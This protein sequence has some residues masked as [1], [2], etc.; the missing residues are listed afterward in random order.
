KEKTFHALT[1]KVEIRHL[2]VK[3]HN[4]YGVTDYSKPIFCTFPTSWP[5]LPNV[6]STIHIHSK[7]P[8]KRPESASKQ[9]SNGFKKRLSHSFQ[10][11]S[12]RKTSNLQVSPTFFP[13]TTY[14]TYTVIA[15]HSP[16]DRKSP[17]KRS[18]RTK[19]EVSS[20]KHGS[21]RLKKGR[22]EPLPV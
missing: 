17:I 21:R 12:K 10:T 2:S 7:C 11:I 18:K 20:K 14:S 19:S 5:S 4:F 22:W 6:P 9:P 16:T 1:K 3:Y 8:R 13:E 15:T